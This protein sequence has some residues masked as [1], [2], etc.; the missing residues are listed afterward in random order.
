MSCEEFVNQFKKIIPQ[1]QQEII[2]RLMPDFC[3][4]KMQIRSQMM[5]G[6]FMPKNWGSRRSGKEQSNE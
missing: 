6:S 1:E 2:T 5:G 4:T 3:T